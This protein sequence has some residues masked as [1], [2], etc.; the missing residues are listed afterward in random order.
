MLFLATFSKLSAKP[1][2]ATAKARKKPKQRGQDRLASAVV[3]TFS[4]VE[5]FFIAE[6]SE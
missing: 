3:V 4:H 5:Q 6:V 2:R 1:A